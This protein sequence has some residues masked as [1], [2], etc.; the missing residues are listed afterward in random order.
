F[1]HHTLTGLQNGQRGNRGPLVYVQALNLNYSMPIT[2]NVKKLAVRKKVHS[3]RTQHHVTGLPARG[4]HRVPFAVLVT[5]D[6]QAENPAIELLTRGAAYHQPQSTV[7][8]LL[9]IDECAISPTCDRT[10][11]RSQV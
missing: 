8:P 6:H 10:S 7:R 9:R 1:A 5:V 2:K 3:K 4:S 11:L